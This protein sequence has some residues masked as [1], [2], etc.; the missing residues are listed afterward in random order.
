MGGISVAEY[1]ALGS[2]SKQEELYMFPVLVL[3][4]FFF[5]YKY[6]HFQGFSR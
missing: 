2:I 6:W 1:K 4:F 5:F 3:S